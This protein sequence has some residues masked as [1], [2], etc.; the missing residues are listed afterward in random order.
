MS[1]LQ[2]GSIISCEGHPCCDR[3]GSLS[4]YASRLCFERCAPEP[5]AIKRLVVSLLRDGK[6][7][8]S[9]NLPPTKQLPEHLPKNSN[10]HACDDATQCEITD[11]WKL[12]ACDDA[13]QCM[14]LV[15]L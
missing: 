13:A 3:I 9:Q 1:L 12:L 11:L 10:S 7:I 14:K 6:M 8:I 15:G 4:V 2:S 5:D